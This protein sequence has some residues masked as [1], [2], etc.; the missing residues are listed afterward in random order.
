MF[1]R[2]AME[3]GDMIIASRWREFTF[4]TPSHLCNG[5]TVVMVI[6]VRSTPSQF[7][8]PRNINK[9]RGTLNN[10]RV[11]WQQPIHPAPI[12]IRKWSVVQAKSSYGNSFS[13]FRPQPISMTLAHM[14][15]QEHRVRVNHLRSFPDRT[16]RVASAPL[17]AGIFALV[18]EAK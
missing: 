8:L 13:L 11:R 5:N 18:L 9:H 4:D 17:A 15:I 16:F 6:R 14:S 7:P 12:S 10:A 3:A 2:L 1:G